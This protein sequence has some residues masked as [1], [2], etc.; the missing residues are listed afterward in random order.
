MNFRLP[1]WDWFSSHRKLPGAYSDPNDNS[2]PTVERDPQHGPDGRN[3]EEDVGEEDV[4]EAALTAD[5]FTEFGGTASG[6]GIPEGTPHGAVHVD[7]GGDMGFF[8]SAGKD[9]V[10]YAHHANVDKMWSDWNKASSIHTNPTAT[11]FLNL[12]WNFYDE[13]KVA[14]DQGLTGPE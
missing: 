1:Y 4:M 8:D 7:V 3:P 14:V 6:S 2:K 10:F 11:A 13:N 12:T 9:P 5:T